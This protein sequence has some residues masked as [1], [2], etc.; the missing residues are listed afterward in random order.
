MQIP[1]GSGLTPS[2]RAG[3]PA[4][5]KQ[6]P[7][8]TVLSRALAALLFLAPGLALVLP[9]VRRPVAALLA[10]NPHPSRE[11]IVQEMSANLCRCG[12]YP[13]ILRAIQRA[14]REG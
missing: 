10:A 14:S 4:A 3:Q 7:V 11:E 12:T 13:R 6:L 2:E 9:A 1:C 8:T 5:P